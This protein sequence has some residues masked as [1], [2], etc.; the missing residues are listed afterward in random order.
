M[1]LEKVIICGLGLLGSSLAMAI[2]KANISQKI[3]GITRNQ[4]TR[5]TA[6]A[7]GI[8]DEVYSNIDERINDSNLIIL[9]TP[10]DVILRQLENIEKHLDNS[11]LL[12]TDVGSTKVTILA[13]ASSLRLSSFVGSHPI[14]GS[15]RRGIFYRDS[16]LFLNKHCFV[17][18]SSESQKTSFY[19]NEITAFWKTIGM[20]VV[21]ISAVDHDR[22]FSQ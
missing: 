14:A 16:S 9:S 5:Q 17:C 11:D 21:R 4:K 15:D 12:I 19:H 10:I 22:S 13:K 2:K 20:K 18:H 7:K 8:V 3:I 1:Q 6:I